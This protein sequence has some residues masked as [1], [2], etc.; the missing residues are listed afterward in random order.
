MN[1]KNLA[2]VSVSAATLGLLFGPAAVQASTLRPEIKDLTVSGSPNQPTHYIQSNNN[3]GCGNIKA[4]DD[5]G[6][7]LASE[8]KPEL[9]QALAEALG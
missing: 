1:T 5:A 6:Q 3:R 7:D 2:L 4:D 8:T 9:L